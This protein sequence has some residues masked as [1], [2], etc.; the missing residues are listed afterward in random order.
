MVSGYC[1]RLQIYS[2][3]EHSKA[4]QNREEKLNKNCVLK[5]LFTL[6]LE[7]VR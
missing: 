7:A 5:M 2:Q 1:H 6:N 3:W 4:S